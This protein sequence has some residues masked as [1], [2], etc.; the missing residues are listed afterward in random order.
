MKFGLI[1]KVDSLFHLVVARHFVFPADLPNV[2][3]VEL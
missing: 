2:C 3:L 1:G